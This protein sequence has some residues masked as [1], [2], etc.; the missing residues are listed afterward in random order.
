MSAIVRIKI[1][2]PL[3]DDPTKV[4][5]EAA[6]EGEAIASIPL[7]EWIEEKGHMD[8]SIYYYPETLVEINGKFGGGSIAQVSIP[9][10]GYSKDTFFRFLTSI[11]GYKFLDPDSDPND[12]GEAIEGPFEW[13]KSGHETSKVQ[14]EYAL[15]KMPY[16]VSSRDY[17]VMNAHDHKNLRWY[18]K[19]IQLPSRLGQTSYCQNNQEGA[20]PSGAFVRMACA[21][22]YFIDADENSNSDCVLRVM[23]WIDMQGWMGGINKGANLSYFKGLQMRAQSIGEL[24]VEKE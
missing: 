17:V 14:A 19:S 1:E 23:Q 3:L 21:V 4:A 2:H 10:I 11:A 24:L 12:F 22:Y 9:I 8:Q 16:C 15:L 18:C 7:S 6:I 13:P 5:D 20:I